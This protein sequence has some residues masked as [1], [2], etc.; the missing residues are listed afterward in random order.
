M[1]PGQ[2]KPWYDPNASEDENRRAR[3]AFEAVLTVTTSSSD[4]PQF[5]EF[6]QEVKLLSKEKFNYNYTEEVST[7]VANFHDAVSSSSN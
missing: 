1:K 4:T 3:K 7:F 6:A 2:Y 5:D